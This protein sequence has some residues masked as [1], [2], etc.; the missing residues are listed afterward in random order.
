L[1]CAFAHLICLFGLESAWQETT[2]A[3]ASAAFMMVAVAVAAMVAAGAP[4]S[5]AAAQAGGADANCAQ[6]DGRC[7]PEQPA[8]ER[9]MERE[10]QG[11]T[12]HETIYKG[13]RI[14]IAVQRAADGAWRA[15]AEVLGGAIAGGTPVATA[16]GGYATE[17][18]AYAAAL[19][20]ATAQ[21]DRARARI[22]KP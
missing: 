7:L 8:V 3:M 20:A 18:E 13:Q 1:L 21:V 12:K 5:P 17:Q 15:S 19:A 2:T 6:P 22:G 4:C 14:R 11:E 9:G 10:M 16:G